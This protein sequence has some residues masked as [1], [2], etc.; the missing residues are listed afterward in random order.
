MKNSIR[1]TNKKHLKNKRKSK[2]IINL[3]N[4]TLRKSL[5]R[6]TSQTN[7]AAKLLSLRN[8]KVSK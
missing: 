8:N 1:T 5:N 6:S 2:K 3:I 7:L 4:N